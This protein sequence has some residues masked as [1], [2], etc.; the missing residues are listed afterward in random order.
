MS[1]V[2]LNRAGH[3]AAV[4]SRIDDNGLVSSILYVFGGYYMKGWAER[5]AVQEP[6]LFVMY[7][8]GANAWSRVAVGG[9]AT[10]AP[11]FFSSLV[12]VNIPVRVLVLFGGE[13]AEDRARTTLDNDVWL[14]W[15]DK[16]EWTTLRKQTP[17]WP[18]PRE[19]HLG[20]V[21]GSKAIYYGGKIIPT[22]DTFLPTDS[23]CAELDIVCSSCEL[24]ALDVG[25]IVSA[26]AG[27]GATGGVESEGALPGDPWMLLSSRECDETTTPKLRHADG[28]VAQGKLA[29]FGGFQG[30]QGKTSNEI[31]TVAPGCVN[32]TQAHSYYTDSCLS[33]PIGSYSP[34]SGHHCCL[35]CSPHTTTSSTGNTV[36]TA[37]ALCAPDFCFSGGVCD[38][39]EA[40]TATCACR[41]G[42]LALDSCKVPWLYISIATAAVLALLVTGSVMY[43]R[44]N[45]RMQLF[46][47]AQLAQT[48]REVEEF[49]RGWEICPDDLTLEKRIDDGAIGACGEVWAGKW[50]DSL[51][52]IKLLNRDLLESDA[53]G[54]TAEFDKEVRF[55]RSIHHPHLVLF[56]GAG[57]LRN[58]RPFLVTEYCEYGSL[59]TFLRNEKNDIGYALKVRFA[60][61]AAKGMRFLHYANPPRIHR[62]LKT[63]MCCDTCAERHAALLLYVCMCLCDFVFFA[64]L[65]I[66]ECLVRLC[67]CLHC[68]VSFASHLYVRL[69]CVSVISSQSAC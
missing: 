40:G 42:Y 67:V 54:Y 43:Y 4:I 9:G 26:A 13:V 31:H 7:D 37:C 20:V 61:D 2:K 21:F 3:A 1:G 46:R 11:R 28:V 5:V 66:S 6:S 49:S 25:M 47:Q 18:S 36:P 55:M 68:C 41:F 22:N 32:G 39:D 53:E 29:M 30:T 27:G 45:K 23:S 69:T 63:G 58:G 52:A 56:F 12:A 10:P 33:C 17:M 15:L 8:V 51:V 65:C 60:T 19:G 62:D 16:Q 34:S 14:F 38:V 44:R 35:V 64:L 57:K 48:Q 24:W 50:Q 59:Q